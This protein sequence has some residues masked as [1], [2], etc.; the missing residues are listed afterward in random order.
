V[1]LGTLLPLL[2]LSLI[3]ILVIEFALLCRITKV[4]AFLGIG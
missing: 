3:F 1:A 2:G 4:K